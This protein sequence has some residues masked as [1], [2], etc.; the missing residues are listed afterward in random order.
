M[1]AECLD[2]SVDGCG[3]FAGDGL[4]GDGFE[5]G[6]VGGLGVVDFGVERNRNLDEPSDAR[7][8]GREVG[9]GGG[10]VEGE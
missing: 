3:G 4:V 1:C 5:E 10:K 8:G 7:I 9:H 6:F 2:P